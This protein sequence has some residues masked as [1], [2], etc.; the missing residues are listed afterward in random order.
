MK[1]NCVSKHTNEKTSKNG[2][3]LRKTIVLCIFA[4]L[5]LVTG[6]AN[7]YINSMVAGELGAEQQVSTSTASFFDNYRTDRQSTRDQELLYLEAIIASTTA[8]SEAKATA[9][10]E[11][12][13]IIANMSL[14]SNLESLIK[15]K[16]FSD[17]V[18]SAMSSNI[19]VIVETSGLDKAQVGQIVDIIQT[20][21]SYA[22][23]NIK[24][25]EV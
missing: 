13:S 20:N 16:G 19:S 25:I 12:Q 1:K 6:G 18:V 9:E 22:L 2:K 24:I 23:D 11:M 7:L 14:T 4:A 15:S 10:A 3:K 17:V 21:T 5:L 8:S